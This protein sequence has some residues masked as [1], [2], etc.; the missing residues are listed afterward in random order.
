MDQP[1]VSGG[2]RVEFE[3][4]G[5]APELAA[6]LDKRGKRYRKVGQFRAIR[7]GQ[8]TPVKTVLADG[9][10]E[11][12]NIAE[13][14]DYIVTGKG[15]ERWVV[16]P[17]TFEARYALKPRRKATYIARG[18]SIAV[19]NPFHRPISLLAPWGERQHGAADCMI[20][21]VVN[22]ATQRRAGEPYIIARAEFDR[23]YEL[24]PAV[25]K[26]VR[27]TAKGNPKRKKP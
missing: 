12:E 5:G 2:K 20:A 10:K 11:T 4:D 1:D 23:T 15:G 21:D 22:P 3:V 14:G 24:V 26:K 6:A 17:E 19:K 25:A 9:T 13:P 7:A 18:E 16:K 8:K 27:P